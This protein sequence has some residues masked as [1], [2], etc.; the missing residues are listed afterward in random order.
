MR[1]FSNPALVSNKSTQY[2]LLFGK[3]EMLNNDA[4]KHVTQI[5]WVNE[6]RV[7]ECK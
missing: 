6:I 2:L 3:N 5:K 7:V 1:C 4:L